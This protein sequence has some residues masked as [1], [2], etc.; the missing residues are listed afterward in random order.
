M[1]LMSGD[2]GRV[3]SAL[4]SFGLILEENGRIKLTQR[5][6]DIAAR[7]DDDPKRIQ[8]IKDAALG[9]AIYRALAREYANGL[10]SDS[11]LHSE[12]IAGKKFN[13]KSVEEFTKDF[14]ATLEFAGIRPSEVLASDQDSD[15]DDESD[16]PLPIRE[17]DYVQWESGGTWQ[18]SM[19]R[20]VTGFSNDGE[21][22]FVEGSS[23]G[24]PVSELIAADPRVA[25]KPQSREKPKSTVKATPPANPQYTSSVLP[26]SVK[27]DV[28]SIGEGEVTVR[29]P[30]SLSPESFEDVSAWLD[31]L[32]RKIGRSVKVPEQQ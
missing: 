5:G 2:V 9:P 28:F 16:N 7:Q 4:K 31:I 1:K 10:P 13:P 12:L 6:V 21:W 29:W 27:Q 15:E 26:P 32:K 8:A 20:R 22:V 3:I 18:F 19:P 23:T 14:R 25:D 24:V 17:G 30:A 11:T